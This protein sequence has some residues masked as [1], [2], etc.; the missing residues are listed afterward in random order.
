MFRPRPGHPYMAGA[1]L[2][3]AHRGGAGLAP[4]NTME[5]FR[6]AVERWE[7]DILEMDVHATAD[8]E[9]VVIHD[10]TVDRT[11]DGRGA[12]RDLTLAEIQRLDAGYRFT[13]LRGT[14]AFRGR[15]VVVPRFVDVLEDFPGVRMNVD[16]KG[17]AT[18]PR[19]IDAVRAAGAEHRVLLASVGE[20]GRAD[21][22]GY[23][24]PTSASRRQIRLFHHLHR[25]PGGG[26]Y[27]PR[28]DALQIPY[29]W[30]GRHVA[31]PRLIREA[32]RRNLAVH[33]W[34]VDDPEVMR[35]LLAWGVGGIQTDR[36]D[37]LAGVL[38]AETGRPPPPGL[39]AP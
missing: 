3:F 22:H 10:P 15:G 29:R 32:S 23:R 20:T 25:L 8:G 30:E 9:L 19:V 5:A 14:H 34:T 13:D 11:T 7:A 6:A 21:R 12:V 28:T 35:T 39:G 31:T 16:A 33:V 37:I 24:G 38:C 1:P 36:P 26:P 18:T 27:T 17:E 2:L 4:E